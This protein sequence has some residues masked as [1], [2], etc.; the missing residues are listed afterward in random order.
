MS[1]DFDAR[2]RRFSARPATLSGIRAPTPEPPRHV[3]ALLALVGAAVLM[4]ATVWWTASRMAPPPAASADAPPSVVSGSRAMEVLRELLPTD[5]P[6]PLGSAENARFR[7]RLVARLRAAGFDPEVQRIWHVEPKNGLGVFV[8]NVIARLPGQVERAPVLVAAH[9]DSP[10]AGPGA[11]GNASSVAAVLEVARALRESPPLARPV[12]FLFSDG[13]EDSQVGARAHVDDLARRGIAMPYA[14]VVIADTLGAAGPN[15]LLRAAPKSGRWVAAWAGLAPRPLSSSLL[16]DVARLNPQASELDVFIESGLPGLHFAS[17]GSPQRDGT[18]ADRSTFVSPDTVQHLADNL[19]AAVSGM[20]GVEDGAERAEGVWFDVATGFV[21]PLGSGTAARLLGAALLLGAI[22]L[23]LTKARGDATVQQVY[24][25]V[26]VWFGSVACGLAVIALLERWLGEQ[27]LVDVPRVAFPWLTV[28]CL[29]A[30]GT[31]ATMLAAVA[32]GRLTNTQGAACGAMLALGLAGLGAVMF[33][34]GTVYL[35]VVPP[36]LAGLLAVLP[37]VR[38]FPSVSRFAFVAAVALLWTPP[39]MLLADAVGVRPAAVVAGVWLVPAGSLVPFIV[40]GGRMRWVVPL[41]AAV[42]SFVAGRG[43]VEMP[44]LTAERPGH[45]SFTYR[46]DGDERTA[47]MVVHEHG[48]GLVPSV[49]ESLDASEGMLASAP[50]D[51][52][53]GRVLAAPRVAIVEPAVESIRINEFTETRMVRFFPVSRRGASEVHLVI[54]ARAPVR[55][56]GINGVSIAPSDCLVPGV[57]YALRLCAVPEE[58]V[59]VE[60]EFVGKSS[61]PAIV[62]DVTPGLPPE[63]AEVV[64]R[65]PPTRVPV[66]KGDRTIA[67]RRVRI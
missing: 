34:P 13:G 5:E 6:H 9:Y 60:V 37:R 49:A 42:A 56:I 48:Q 18:A 64:Q 45:M 11:A 57:G 30:A 16:Q 54:D 67:W 61:W 66:G 20:A 44:R 12:T 36:L 1:I 39:A 15:L 27:G 8:H 40:E 23:V 29:A 38:A 50:W 10:Q 59:E 65:R 32:S 24:R 25:G 19:L 17:V 4:V 21:V 46:F 35:F 3:R 22:A 47:R 28:G 7:V 52:E 26:L 33:A 2:T 51:A 41:A 58:S 62:G 43:I 63:C 14:S 53:A 55:R 31:A